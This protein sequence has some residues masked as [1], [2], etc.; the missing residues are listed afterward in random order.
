MDFYFNTRLGS[1]AEVSHDRAVD[2]ES[3]DSQLSA[4]EALHDDDGYV[5]L[6]QSPDLCTEYAAHTCVF[7]DMCVCVRVVF[8]ALCVCVCWCAR[9]LIHDL[10]VH[11]QSIG[12]IDWASSETIAHTT[13]R[14]QLRAVCER[15]REIKSSLQN[16][17]QLLPV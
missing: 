3:H 13:A 14:R 12:V 15:V 11:R 5:L 8:T 6:A 2:F 7:L 17:G 1:A 16:W 4:L 9:T 10:C